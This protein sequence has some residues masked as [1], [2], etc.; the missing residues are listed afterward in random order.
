MKFGGAFKSQRLFEYETVG[1]SALQCTFWGSNSKTYRRK[2]VQ[3]KNFKHIQAHPAQNEHVRFKQ[4]L[5]GISGRSVLQNDQKKIYDYRNNY[6]DCMKLYV[7]YNR[8]E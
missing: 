4:L 3:T 7:I 2:K 6:D 1:K 8:C 5:V